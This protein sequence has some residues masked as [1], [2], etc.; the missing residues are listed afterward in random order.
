[1]QKTGRIATRLELGLDVLWKKLLELY[2]HADGHGQTDFVFTESA[3][4]HVEVCVVAA[5]TRIEFK[6]CFH[7]DAQVLCEHVLQTETEHQT[8]VIEPFLFYAVQV[9]MVN[10]VVRPAGEEL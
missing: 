5:V 3:I 4:V 8:P 2:G 9:F 10:V 7:E 6:A 1:M